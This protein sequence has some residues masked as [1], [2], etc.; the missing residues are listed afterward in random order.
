MRISLNSRSKNTIWLILEKVLRLG[1][2]FG[3]NIYVIRYLSLSDYGNFSYSVSIISILSLISTL[4]VDQIGVK[5]FTEGEYRR[6]EVLSTAFFLRLI[7]SFFLFSLVNGYCL[8]WPFSDSAINT[9]IHILSITLLISPFLS[10]DIYFQ[11]TLQ[12]KYFSFSSFYGLIA[13][14]AA[15]IIGL[16]S[17]LSVLFFAF[18]N[19]I[20]RFVTLGFMGLYFLKK[21]PKS[22]VKNKSRKRFN[23][24]LARDLIFESWPILSSLLMV[25]LY[26]RMDQVMLMSMVGSEQVALYSA[27]VKFSEVFFFIPNAIIVSYFPMLVNLRKVDLK[28]YNKLF[29]KVMVY[30][31]RIALVVS[32]V[33]LLIGN[34]VI[35]ILLGDKYNGTGDLLKIHILSSI[36]AFVGIVGSRWIVI[37]KCTKITLF[38]TAIGLVINLSLNFILIPKFGGVGA[39]VASLVSQSFSSFFAFAIFPASRPLF[40][41][42]CRSLLNAV[43]PFNKNI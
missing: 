40:I 15:K 4:G 25:S 35:D 20:E 23:A 3:V 43:F 39:A 5:Y 27:S 13:G 30:L 29:V 16:L 9:L 34:N 18:C 41:L 19:V 7:W 6:S 22:T 14:S 24:S 37:E 11:S 42:Q 1:I 33:T 38:R 26:M 12:S 8:I 21:I 32:I 31:L 10:V 36:F 28:G 2:G 17:S